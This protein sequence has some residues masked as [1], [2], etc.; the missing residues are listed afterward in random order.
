MR[1]DFEAIILVAGTLG[2]AALACARSGHRTLML[3]MQLDSI[4]RMSQS[5]TGAGPELRI[6]ARR[7]IVVH[8][9]DGYSIQ[10]AEPLEGLRTRRILPTAR[11]KYDMK[12][13]WAGLDVE[14]GRGG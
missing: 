3:T 4:A 10:D 5:G 1:T 12:R 11:R 2:G 7:R 14:A 9:P 8:R 13:V 6:D